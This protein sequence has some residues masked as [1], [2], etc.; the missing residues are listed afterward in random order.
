MVLPDN[1]RHFRKVRGPR[2]RRVAF[3][4]QGGGSLRDTAR[5]IDEGYRL[6]E[7]WLAGH[8]V[9]APAVA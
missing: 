6:A 7:G 9:L 4:F 5:L 3:V 1:I 2:A 8:P